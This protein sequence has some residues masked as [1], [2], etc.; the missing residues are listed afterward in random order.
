MAFDA[1]YYWIRELRSQQS[2]P[3][4]AAPTIP[5]TS[6]PGEEDQTAASLSQ[7]IAG[8]PLSNYRTNMF[9]EDESQLADFFGATNSFDDWNMMTDYNELL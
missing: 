8:M 6:G 9:T 1:Y 2:G 7:E 4:V 3:S 5:S